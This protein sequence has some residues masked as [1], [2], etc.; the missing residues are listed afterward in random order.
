MFNLWGGVT[1]V[2]TFTNKCYET[3]KDT[4]GYI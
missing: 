2:P 3:R 1:A 4:I